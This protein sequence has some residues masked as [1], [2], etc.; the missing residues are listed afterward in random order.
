MNYIAKV[1][2]GIV[3]QVIVAQDMPGEG[4]VFVGPDNTVG[5]GWTYDGAAFV[6][7]MVESE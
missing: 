2:G 4:W 1:E 6:P 7:P 3:T 5:V